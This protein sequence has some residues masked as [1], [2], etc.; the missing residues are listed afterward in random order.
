MKSEITKRA[1]E[2][3][4]NQTRTEEILW[5]LIRRKN[6][7]VKFRR[8]YPIIF[9]EGDERHCFIADFVCLE[10]KLILELDGL[11]HDSKK[12]YDSMRTSIVNQLGFKV[13]RF[14]NEQV[15]KNVEKVLDIIKDH[16]SSLPQEAGEG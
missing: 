11:I 5:S 12:E 4:K 6:L 14:D 16:L 9:Y 13:V 7:G 10:K 8:Q 1:R 2:L 3:R 15:N